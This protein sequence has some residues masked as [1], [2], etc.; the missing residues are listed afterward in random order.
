[1]TARRFY[2]S[3]RF[4]ITV[5]VAVPLLIILTTISYL[6]YNSHR[7]LMVENL[8]LSASNTGDI[9]EASLQH[10]MLTN[11]FSEVQQ[12]VDE[13]AKREGIR[14][15]FLLDKQG[16][17]M[18]SAAGKQVG[19]VLSLD[20]PTC[21]ACHQHET[22]NRNLSMVFTSMEG[23]R[24]FR[25]LNP[26]D[27]RQDCQGCHDPQDKLSGVLITDFSMADIDRHLAIDR[28]NSLLWS[29]GTIVV[30]ILIFGLMMNRLVI[31]KLERFA[32]AIRSLGEGDLDR[33]VVLGGKDEIDGLAN[34]FNSM[35][36]GLR[37]KAKLERKVKRRTEELQAQTERLST[38]NTIAATVSQSLNLEE[39]LHSALC[40]VLE[41]MRL[42]AGWIFLP[43]RQ[44]EMLQLAVHCGL[45]EAFAQAEVKQDL[46]GC[47]CREV[48]ETGQTMVFENMARCPRLNPELLEREGLTYH[49]S[50]PLKSKDTVLGIINVAGDGR[51]NSPPFTEEELQLLTAIGQQIGV[52]VENAALYE[53]LH[54]KESLRGQLL[55]KV[56]SAQEEERKRIARELHDETGQVLTSLMVGLKVLEGA[57]SLQEVQEKASQLRAVAAQTLD[58]VHRLA[59]ELRPSVLDDLGLVAAMQRYVKDWGENF[60]L[61]V[62]FQAT[63]L[64]RRLAPQVETTVY[65]VVQEALTNVVRHAKAQSVSVLLE[66]RGD[67][68][69]CIV[70]DDGRG[71]DVTSVLQANDMRR[72]GLY[73]MQERISLVGGKLAVESSAGVGTTVFVEIPLDVAPSRSRAKHKER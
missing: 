60:G 15:L 44:G 25:N 3:L 58:S 48:F 64:D 43:D 5:G 54:Q 65:R 68:V 29:V 37:E 55:E 27:N 11:D 6:Q 62:D 18:M 39:I 30:T 67:S 63:G 23:E 53:E 13:I 4:K 59:L 35:V 47:I 71:F 72:L 52:A 2:H 40:K 36:D 10:A 28:R 38:L 1:M 42:R 21:Q 70:E 69:V 12:I 34:S 17:I 7:D 66:Y 31:T 19:T 32:E 16:R 49:A 61:S 33:Q 73:G 24:V 26:I 9:I 8:R 14:D 41:L 50:V 46:E 20:D 57:A 45:S 22:V 56:I 51:R